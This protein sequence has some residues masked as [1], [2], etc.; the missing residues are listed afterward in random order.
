MLT[1]QSGTYFNVRSYGSNAWEGDVETGSYVRLYVYSGSL[2]LDGNV[3]VPSTFYIYNGTVA[4]NSLSNYVSYLYVVSGTAEVNGILSSNSRPY[5]QNSNSTLAGLGTFDWA[6]ASPALVRGTIDPGSGSTTGILTLDDVG[7]E[8]AYNPRLSVQLNGTTAGSGHDQLKVNGTVEIAGDL[9]VTLGSSFTTPGETFTILDNDGTEPITG[10]FN[11]LPEGGLVEYGG[12]IFGITYQGGTGNDIVL[13]TLSTNNFPT[14]DNQAVV[15]NEET[16]VGITLTGSDID[17]DPIAFSIESNPS[18]GSLSGSGAN[19]TYTPFLNFAG[20]DSF[21]FRVTDPDGGFSIATVSITVN[22]TPDSPTQVNLSNSSLNENTPSGSTVGTLSTTDPDVGDSFIYTLVSGS[23]DTDNAA[24]A[25]SGDQLKSVFSPDFETKSSYSVRVRST[26]STGNWVERSYTVSINDVN[27]APTTIG[28]SSTSIDENLSI[29]AVVGSF[30]TTDPDTTDSHIYTLVAGAGS[31]DNAA[32]TID[33]DQLKLAVIPDFESKESYEIRVRSTDSGFL[34]VERQFTISIEDVNEAPTANNDGYTVS[35]ESL[36]DPSAAVQ[37]LVNDLDPEDDSLIVTAINGVAANVGTQ[38]TLPSGAML[39]LQADGSFVYDPRDAFD[40]LAAGE[41]DSDSFTYTISDGELTSTATVDITINGWNDAPQLTLPNA[42]TPTEDVA[43]AISGIS[44]ANDDSSDLTV[45]LVVP[46]GSLTLGTVT[47]V[48]FV[49]GTANGTSA[50][51]FSGAIGDLNAALASLSY[52]SETNLH[53][54]DDLDVDV[55]ESTTSQLDLTP[56]GYNWGTTSPSSTTFDG[57]GVYLRANST[58]SV[59]A[60]DWYGRLASSG[61]YEVAIY[62]GQ[63]ESAPLGSLLAVGNQGFSGGGSFGWNQVP[64][65]F[66]FQAGQQYYVNFRRTDGGSNFASPFHFMSW[67]NGSQASNLGD[68]T[69]LDGRS[70]FAPSSDNNFWLTHFRFSQLS[71]GLS[72]SGT[73]DITV[74]ADADA[75]SLTAPASRTGSE[76]TAIS[77][78]LSAS[79]Q[80]TDGSE[81][82]AVE[83]S[84]I[85]ADATFSNTNGDVLTPVGGVLTLNDPALQ[86]PGLAITLPDNDSFTLQV[87]ATATESS[88]NDVATSVSTV[89]ITAEN[90]APKLESLAITSEIDENQFATLTGDIIDPG[91][92]SYTIVVDWGEGSPQTYNIPQGATSFVVQHQYLDDGLSPG[93]GSESDDYTVSIISFTDDDGGAADLLAASDGVQGGGGGLPIVPQTHEIRIVNQSGPINL[94]GRNL[95]GI[96]TDPTTGNVYVATGSGTAG[97][98]GFFDL[99]RITPLGSVSF[100]RSYSITYVEGPELEFGPDGRIYTADR[101]SGRIFAIDP[102]TGSLSLYNSGG[103]WGSLNRYGLDFDSSGNLILMRESVPNRFFRVN[104][105]S[106]GTVLGDNQILLGREH[107]DRFGIQPDGDYV[108]YPDANNFE[109][110]NPVFELD[111]AGHIPGTTYPIRHLSST[112]NYQLG[113]NYVHSI[114]AI[115]P[116]NG[117]VYYSTMNQGYGSTRI[118]FAPGN[119][120]PTATSTIFVDNIGNGNEAPASTSSSRGLTDLDFGPRS[121][122]RV[123]NSLF[124]LDD[125][126]DRVYEVRELVMFEF[127]VTVNNVAPDDLDVGLD[128]TLLP[129]D[130]GQFSRAGITFTDPGTLDV[131]TV[132]V[133]WDGDGIY[134]ELVALNPDGRSF[135]ISHTYTTEGVF[136]VNVRVSD[137]DGGYAIDSFDVS[138]DLNNPPAA[139]DG[140]V[141][142]LE[143]TT[144]TYTVGDFNFSDPDAGDTLAAVEITTLPSAGTLLLDTNGGSLSDAIIVSALDVIEAADIDAGYLKF[145]PATHGSGTPYDSF[146][147]RVSDGEEFSLAS[148]AMTIDVVAVADAPTLSVTNAADSE[149]TAVTLDVAVALVDQDGSETLTLAINGVPIGA[150]LS[151]GTSSFTGTAGSDSV[152]VTA[153]NLANLTITPPLH[154]DGEFVLTVTATA[155]ENSNGST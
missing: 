116:N 5:L 69:L 62:R 41:T 96:A 148:Y 38:I 82:L 10:I 1:S 147:F 98:Y 92:D 140:N 16:S 12:N 108:V 124:F 17:G 101:I 44:I 19:R 120:G 121:D 129:P 11:G 93:N 35:E 24:F 79:L 100:V 117:D 107:G 109:T 4:F 13:T 119:V 26:D 127:T 71:N 88:N 54:P 60:I 103:P 154:S 118:A 37:I 110:N 102:T 21:Q 47:G 74:I 134:D 65:N 64:L 114:G 104:P 135:D 70:G 50:L 86:L 23:G 53:G 105:G 143:D 52:V 61:Q 89:S 115:D 49:N 48:T 73:I 56:S 80:D 39:T 36:L 29:G 84:N 77:L 125:F 14:A 85:P 141:G 72:D 97:T 6:S 22:N 40:G 90:A 91:N 66:T 28:L 8:G 68:V 133:D 25:I 145:Q 128:A 57:R 139:T 138:V 144:Y 155:T 15:T 136:T 112:H 106:G 75:P 150:T 137:D 81:T 42:Q 76:G 30:S 123:G 94:S 55:W 95:K 142:T 111:T 132:E 122:D 63:G 32:F 87:V 43:Q 46:S 33:G 58:F 9:D 3:D 126:T 78:D 146:A 151:D 130:E 152:D 31:T 45:R 153:W 20:S 51:Q 27:E 59:N 34:S 83:L 67:G 7:F 18:H 2:Q 113:L 149:D 99:Y 131:H